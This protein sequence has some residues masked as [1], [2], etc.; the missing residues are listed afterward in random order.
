MPLFEPCLSFD[1]LI[2]ARLEKKRLIRLV[3]SL[4][5]NI[6]LGDHGRKTSGV[7]SE[8][9]NLLNNTLAQ[10]KKE[11][12]ELNKEDYLSKINK[13]CQKKRH[14]FHFWSKPHS[15]SEFKDLVDSLELNTPHNPKKM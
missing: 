1:R 5:R 11:G 8:K 14:F 10:L 12:F 4:I 2:S 15:V 13:I 9:V 6:E 7:D 3:E